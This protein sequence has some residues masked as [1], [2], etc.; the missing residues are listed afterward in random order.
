MR[1]GGSFPA[2]G[3]SVRLVVREGSPVG[4]EVGQTSTFV[5]GPQPVGGTVVV[6]FDFTPPLALDPQGPF[7]LQGPA[8]SPA[9]LT[10]FGVDSDPYPRGT[11]FNCGGSPI[12]TQDLNFVTHLPGDAGAP[13]TTITGGPAEGTVSKDGKSRFEFTGSDDLSYPA[14]LRFECARDGGEFVACSSPTE[15]DSPDGRHRLA[16]RASDEAGQRDTTPAVRSWISDVTPPTRP[17][18]LGPRRASSLALTYR[19]LATD[20]V[21]PSSKIRFRCSFDTVR[22]R[23]CSAR[24]RTRLKPGKH[25]LR[26]RA[27]DSVG[28]QSK[29]AMVSIDIRRAA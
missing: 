11:S 9:I 22:L 29:L 10:W 7:V 17:R 27:V 25:L 3:L 23:P 8:L 19:F 16:V 13:E 26:V 20:T 6:H 15:L 2:G 12:P 28:H 21:T 4:R 14:N 18:V 5:A 24:V 1:T